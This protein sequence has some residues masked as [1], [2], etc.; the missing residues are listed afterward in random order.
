VL[1]DLLVEGTISEQA[2]GAFDIDAQYDRELKPNPNV[3]VKLRI[4]FDAEAH[5]TEQGL[6]MKKCE[7]K[8]TMVIFSGGEIAGSENKTEK[9][10][11]LW[12]KQ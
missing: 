7:W 5:P 11:G 12:K 2:G 3:K 10:V 9:C 6:H 1:G 4:E 8:V